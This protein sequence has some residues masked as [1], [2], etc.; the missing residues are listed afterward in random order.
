MVYVVAALLILG[1]LLL[2]GYVL[3]LDMVFTP[4]LR[5]PVAGSSYLLQALL[6]GLDRLLPADLVQKLLLLVIFMLAGVGMHRLWLWLAAAGA[7]ASVGAET[8]A[9]K[10][11][12]SWPV[13]APYFAGLLY[14]LN[15][16]TYDRFVT[17]QYA[18]LFGYALLPWLVRA[19]LVMAWRPGWRTAL[20]AAAWASAVGVVSIHSLGMAAVIAGLALVV[21][22]W[23]LRRP[24]SEPADL[25]GLTGPVGWWQRAWPLLRA[26]LLAVAVWLL[27]SAYWL[28]PA[29]TGRGSQVAAVG[30]FTGADRLAFATTGEA[31]WQRLANVLSLQGFWAER[32]GLFILPQDTVPGWLWYLA[33]LV[34]WLLVAAGVVA[35][36]RR[37]QRAWLA[38]F[39]G[40]VLLGAG[41]AA[42]IGGGWLA[43]WLP[44]FAGYREPQKF[45]GLVALGFCVLAAYGAG[46]L[47]RRAGRLIRRRAGADGGAAEGVAGGLLLVLPVVLAASMPWAAAGQLQAAAYPDG[48]YRVNQRLETEAGRFRVLALPWHLYLHSNMAGRVVANPAPRFFDN[49]GKP[50]VGSDD[51]EYEGAALSRPTALTR[52]LDGLLRN[53]TAGPPPDFSRQLARLDIKY[54]ILTKDADYEDYDWLGR[55]PGLR[56][57]FD[58]PTI[59]LYQNTAFGR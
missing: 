19:V 47:V 20:L 25:A 43:E 22:L 55:T 59:S 3:A 35:L 57:V 39:G 21:R 29:L 42:G 31:T 58:D 18:V 41:L 8:G 24:G 46:S 1:P 56:Q 14:V 52:Q 38:I 36:W 23:Q 17:G 7:D 4:E 34:L 40:C 32:R 10:R 48:W 53:A 13:L 11:P 15:P 54:V 9:G 16:F 51:P 49:S 26:G 50:V 37:R 2:P 33:V 30:S 6:Y 45:A 12:G 44:F 27:A 28:V 5:P